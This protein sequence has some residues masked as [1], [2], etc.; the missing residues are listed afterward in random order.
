MEEE[1]EPSKNFFYLIFFNI[2]LCLLFNDHVVEAEERV[3]VFDYALGVC[4]SE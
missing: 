3:I 2:S 1:E 4:S